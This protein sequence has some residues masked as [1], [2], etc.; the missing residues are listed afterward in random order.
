MEIDGQLT[1]FRV[2]QVLKSLLI[3]PDAT[4]DEGRQW[5]EDM[6]EQI[7]TFIEERRNEE[8]ELDEE[9]D[10][11]VPQ[12][13]VQLKFFEC[14]AHLLWWTLCS[15][16]S[17]SHSYTPESDIKTIASKSNV[18]GNVNFDDFLSIMTEE[19]YDD[20]DLCEGLC[21]VLNVYDASISGEETVG[22]NDDNEAIAESRSKILEHFKRCCSKI[23]EADAEPIAMQLENGCYLYSSMMATVNS[24]QDRLSLMRWRECYLAKCKQITTWL[25]ETP[26]NESHIW[27]MAGADPSYALL[28]PFTKRESLFVISREKRKQNLDAAMRIA[29]K[30][31]EVENDHSSIESDFKCPKCGSFKTA[32]YLKQVRSADEPM[33]CFWKCYF[34]NKSGREG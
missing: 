25:I 15:L 27:E 24:K 32:S 33:T 18:P 20:A 4:E 7:S 19:H 30:K 21:E 14:V 29:K 10:G 3:A 17:L 28:V 5:I 9:Q 31:Y 12:P 1:P 22:T 6:D 11:E 2:A 23:M 34:C 8:E 16:T 26:I 13:I